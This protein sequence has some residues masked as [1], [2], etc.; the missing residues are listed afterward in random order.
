MVVMVAIWTV[1]VKS[2]PEVAAVVIEMKCCNFVSIA[3]VFAEL[4]WWTPHP[5]DS[6]LLYSFIVFPLVSLNTYVL[7]E[8][9]LN[10]KKIENEYRIYF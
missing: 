7:D 3:Q 4:G 1:W 2:L 8:H 10:K 5:E 6:I 9:P